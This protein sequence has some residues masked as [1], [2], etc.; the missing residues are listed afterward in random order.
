MP[1]WRVETQSAEE[2]SVGVGLL[3]VVEGPKEP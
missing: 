2:K 1:F 3:V